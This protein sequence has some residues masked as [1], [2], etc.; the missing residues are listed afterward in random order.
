M[1]LLICLFPILSLFSCDGNIENKFNTNNFSND[2]D[3]T[4]SVAP[5]IIPAAERL[6]LYLPDIRN[7][8][9]GIVVN[10]TSIVDQTHLVDTL[11]SLDVMIEKI[12]APEHG[13]KG[14][15]DA[16]E[17]VQDGFYKDIPVISLYGKNRKP[18]DAQLADLDVIL[19][20]IQDVGVRF[21]TYISTMSYVM[22]AAAKNQVP[23]LILDRPNPN[24]FYVD[25]PV[26]E[27]E[28]SSFVGLHEVPVVY[29][30]TIGEYAQMVNGE[31]WLPE[32]LNAELKVIPCQ[33]YDHTMTYDLPVKPSP[34][35]PNLK[36]ILLYPSL[37][38][39]EGTTVSI[40]RGTN[41]QFQIIG[42]P[43]IEQAAFTFTPL[44]GEGAANPKL[45]GKACN[46]IDLT[47]LNVNELMKNKEINI[48]YILE[49]HKNITDKK[50]QF[51]NNNNFFEKLA[52]TES[53]RD[54]IKAGKSAAQIKS[55]WK[56]KLENFKLIRKNYLLYKDFE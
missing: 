45:N 23:M 49:F 44:P 32:S 7:K 12:F 20:D 53:F 40:G 2:E 25:G 31:G 34:N 52:G 22:E 14:A 11:L 3:F 56:S 48:D 13:F 33:N 54:A 6:Q 28:F 21:Y 18:T 42:H 36:S 38:F 47:I 37:C 41:K 5:P 1:G 35:L 10:H 16:G 9:V 50:S 43:V 24:G 15:A 8:K 30:M 19:F 17:K 39:F 46:G 55:S 26:L 4:I 27:Q 51:F 29:G